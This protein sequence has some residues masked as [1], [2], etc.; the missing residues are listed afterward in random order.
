MLPQVVGFPSFLK[1]HSMPVSVCVCVCVWQFLYSFTHGHLLVSLFWLL[2]TMVQWT[3]RGTYLSK[4]PLSII[5][6][7]YTEVVRG[8]DW[9]L[10]I[11]ICPLRYME[12]LANRDLSYS[13][14]NST[15][16]PVII[17]VGKD[18]EKEWIYVSYNW[19]TLLYRR[20]YH[21]LVNQLYVNKT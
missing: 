15:Q 1:L 7:A 19:I 5:L 2:W 3:W 16:Y 17:Y 14:G 8:V 13:T 20:N 11:G 9:G 10:V 12:W 21:N 18:S 6:D 4:I